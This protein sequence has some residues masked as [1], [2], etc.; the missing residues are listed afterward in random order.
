MDFERA[1]NHLFCNIHF[2]III[3]VPIMFYVWAIQLIFKHYLTY[4]DQMSDDRIKQDQDVNN[5]NSRCEKNL[6]CSFSYFWLYWLWR[7]Y[8]YGYCLPILCYPYKNQFHYYY[9]FIIISI[10]LRGRFNCQWSHIQS[11]ITLLFALSKNEVF[12]FYCS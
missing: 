9:Y 5:G 8:L 2:F 10:L 7:F 12:F 6:K 1:N 11:A 4:I 3:F